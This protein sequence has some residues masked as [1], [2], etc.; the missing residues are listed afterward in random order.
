MVEVHVVDDLEPHRKGH[1]VLSRVTTH[2]L[3][4]WVPSQVDK[5]VCSQDLQPGVSMPLVGIQYELE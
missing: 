4:V 3:L 5:E 2:I 1:L